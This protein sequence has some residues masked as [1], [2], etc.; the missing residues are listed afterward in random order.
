MLEASANVNEGSILMDE[1]LLKFNDSA[2]QIIT[3]SI[4]DTFAGLGNAIGQALA[5]ADNVLSAVGKT[6]LSSLGGILIEIGKMAISVGVGLLGIK[7][8]LKTLNPYAA[9]GAGVALIALGSFFASKS[10]S[11]GNSMGGGGSRASNSSGAGANNQSFSSSG[12]GGGGG[13]GTVVFEI[14]GQKLIGVL[15]NTINANRRLGGTL[16]LG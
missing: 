4:A 7:A 6:L 14:S 10:S 2:T 11:I 15:S 16:G 1:A 3:T 8:A 13:S 12:F 9:I 5:T